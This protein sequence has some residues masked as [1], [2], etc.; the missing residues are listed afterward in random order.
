MD[1]A[2]T[3]WLSPGTPARGNAGVTLKPATVEVF[4]RL[5]R[6]K[7]FSVA[8]LLKNPC[9]KKPTGIGTSEGRRVLSFASAC[10]N[11]DFAGSMV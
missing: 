11:P 3:S 8:L 4:M 1:A 6:V 10:A 7:P 9:R 5:L 2:R